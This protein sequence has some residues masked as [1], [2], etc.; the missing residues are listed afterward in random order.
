[1]I[2]SVSNVSFGTNIHGLKEYLN[3]ATYDNIMTDEHIDVL[4][5]LKND[6][7]ETSLS[8][9][10]DVK[11]EV[12]AVSLSSPKIEQ[13]KT[14]VK[15]GENSKLVKYAAYN[16]I[17]AQ[18]KNELQSKDDPVSKMIN[19]G[20]SSNKEKRDWYKDFMDLFTKENGIEES[21][22][23][24]EERFRDLLSDYEYV[25]D[26]AKNQDADWKKRF[27]NLFA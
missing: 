1:M 13:V 22:K 5:K 12:R 6:G 26:S 25:V 17:F 21:I 19:G 15:N 10:F 4:E 20:L 9:D 16:K 7:L 18:L 2:K 27:D 11:T 23:N 3:C 8:V 14:I 24:K